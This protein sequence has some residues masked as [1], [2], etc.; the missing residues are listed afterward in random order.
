[1]RFTVNGWLMQSSCQ[2]LLYQIWETSYLE[3]A[4]KPS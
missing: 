2:P 4:V 1:M 3:S